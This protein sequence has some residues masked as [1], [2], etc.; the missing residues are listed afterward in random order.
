MEKKNVVLFGKNF[1]RIL[2]ENQNK[3]TWTKLSHKFEK[4]VENSVQV[5]V[6]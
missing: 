2:Y 5:R 4:I 6:I 3:R 1:H